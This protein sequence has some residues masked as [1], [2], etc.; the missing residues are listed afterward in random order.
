MLQPTT[1]IAIVGLYMALLF[2]IAQLVE[3]YYE[4]KPRGLSSPLIYALSITIY[5]TSWTFYGSVGFAAESGLL[6]FAIYIGAILAVMFWWRFLRGM[7]HVKENYHIS[8]IA[9]FISARYNR[10]QRVAALVTLIAL[11]GI[12]PYIALQLKAVIETFSLMSATPADAAWD[13]TGVLVTALMIVFT[14]AFGARRLDPTERHPGMM[15]V[16]AIQSLLKLVAFIAVGL[17]VTYGLYDGLADITQRIHW[18]GINHLLSSRIPEGS[19][20]LHWATLIILGAASIQCLPRQFHVAVVENANER[21][22]LTAAWVVPLYLVAISFFVIPIAGA[23]LIS[24]L[25]YAQADSFVLLLPQM[26]G[27]TELAVLVF[28]GGFSAAAGMVI[29]SAM[30][31]STMA[32]NHLLLPCIERLGMGNALRHYLLQCRWLVIALIIGSAYLF[33]RAFSDSYMLVAMGMISFVAVFQ[34]VPAMFLGLL[35]R[36]GNRGGAIAGLTAGML[37]WAYTL[38]LP[39]L[40]RQGWLPT[41]LLTL[42]PLGIS[43]LRP[44]AL[45]GLEGLSA[46]SHSVLWSALFNL[47]G[48]FLGSLTYTPSKLERTQLTEFINA[49][50]SG[51]RRTRGMATGLDAYIPMAEKRKEASLL[52]A[53]YLPDD[54]ADLEVS[55]VCS[56]LRIGHKEYLTIIELLEFHRRLEH[57]L[58]GA[59]GTAGA[60]QALE[61]SISY[62][63]REQQDLKAIYSHIMVELKQQEK[64]SDGN[65]TAGGG[66]YGLVEK[67]QQ[68]IAELERELEA[69]SQQLERLSDRLSRSDEKLFEQRVLNQKLNQEL[70]KQNNLE[71]GD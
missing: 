34:F 26:A 14:I 59:I 3:K 46:V 48:Y 1:V 29:I 16:L 58:A 25:D 52:L 5:C 55:E 69:Q 33:A 49:L 19:L 4:A 71:P 11:F 15:V 65:V 9:D 70:A 17:F 7:V 50:V 42:G 13:V 63:E 47:L 18:T 37:L 20:F 39:A 57:V 67:L 66:Q 68:R 45:F 23:G 44:E 27:E 12:V 22:I 43:W 28:V 53:Q 31:L 51:G 24:G 40:V 36:R 38:V 21:H 32:T 41:E 54:K 2:V 35:W 61:T 56:D 64:R 8:S 60:H 30:T 6:Y 62:S 10:S